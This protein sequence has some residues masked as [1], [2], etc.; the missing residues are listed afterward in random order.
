MPD[1]HGFDHL[2]DGGGQ[3]I[4][5]CITCGETGY[6]W[7]WPEARRDQHAKA[8]ANGGGAADIAE[9]E[10][11]EALA[12]RERAARRQ[13]HAARRVIPRPRECANPYCSIV[14]QPRR[15]TALYCSTRCRVAAHRTKGAV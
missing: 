8:H 10:L 15:I 7:K 2:T 5:R 13:A 3:P 12:E 9:R 4:L 1:R 11:T 6:S 14:F